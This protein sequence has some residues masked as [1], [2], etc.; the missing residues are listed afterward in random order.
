M[1]PSPTP[2]GELR[3]GEASFQTGRPFLFFASR[4]SEPMKRMREEILRIAR[5]RGLPI[6][7]AADSLPELDSLP[8]EE[9]QIAC[10]D[11]VRKASKFVCVLDGSYGAPLEVSETCILELELASA[12]LSRRDI[13]VF[14]VEPFELDPRLA[15]ILETLQAACPDAID[16]VAKRRE[17]IPALVTDWSERLE[18]PSK[19]RGNLFGRL[20]QFL[21][22]KRTE[23]YR[24]LDVLFL[25]GRVAPL[26]PEPPDKERIEILLRRSAEEDKA[27]N[28]LAHLWAAIRKLSAAPYDS[29]K[30]RDFLPLWHRALG[31]WASASAWYGLHGHFLIGRLAAVNT[32]VAIREK[33]AREDHDDEMAIQGTHGSIAS[34][35]YS[36]AK[37]VPRRWDRRK[38]L[39]RALE[40]VTFALDQGQP[41]P[42]GL[43]AIRGS[44]RLALG[45]ARLAVEDYDKSLKVRVRRGEDQGRIGEAEVELAMG[46]L[47]SGRIWKV[48]DLLEQGVDRLRGSHRPEFL[49]RALR[50][51]GFFY[52]L[53]LRRQR[54]EEAFREALAIAT[55]LELEGQSRQITAEMTRL[56]YRPAAKP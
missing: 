56:R 29:P 8:L 51:L 2:E 35:Y 22:R 33:L 31:R 6:W 16:W 39:E 7:L 12:L 45:E 9:V 40:K 5:A 11:R 53:T 41:D 21:A 54:S 43:L 27:P 55:R 19:P 4:M 52:A 17:D 13:S 1:K 14:L 44:V 49:V 32:I 15:G 3:L 25:D 24:D 23:N 20:V 10:M 46:Y 18:A 42:S 47:R 30:F 28:K 50:K 36:I 48:K 37:Q 34:E 26:S 38:L